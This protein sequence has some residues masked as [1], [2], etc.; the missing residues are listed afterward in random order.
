ML[1]SEK[2]TRSTITGGDPRDAFWVPFSTFEYS[3]PAMRGARLADSRAINARSTPSVP[4]RRVFRQ[5]ALVALLVALTCHGAAALSP[6]RILV[7]YNATWSYDAD[8]D[9][10]QDSMEAAR[11]YC[12]ERSVPEANML[13]VSLGTSLDVTPETLQGSLLTPL[14]AK[15]NGLGKT[16][17]DCILTVIGIPRRYV[18]GSSIR[19]IDAILMAPFSFQQT[20][21]PNPYHEP[22]PTFGN[23]LGTFQHGQST[24]ISGE[25]M[26]LV[27]RLDSPMG[28][29]GV[30]NQID[31]CTYAMRYEIPNANAYVDSIGLV[32]NP[33]TDANL[34]SHDYVRHGTYHTR[35]SADLNI[36]WA[37]HFVPSLTRL[38]W[39]QSPLEIGDPGAMIEAAP[40]CWI[41]AGWYNFQKYQDVIEWLPGSIGC[42]VDSSSAAWSPSRDDRRF[43]NNWENH[44][45]L[46]QAWGAQ[47]MI[48]GATCILG[49]VTEPFLTGHQRPHVAWWS[50]HRG[51]SFAEAATL[52]TPLIGWVTTSIGDPLFSWSGSRFPDTTKPAIQ[53]AEVTHSERDGCVLDVLLDDGDLATAMVEVK[54]GPTIH[55]PQFWRR[56]RISISPPRDGQECQYR[57]TLTDPSGNVSMR[58]DVFHVPGQGPQQ[59]NKV[60]G[61][62]QLEDFDVGGEGIAYHDLEPGASWYRRETGVDVLGT[63]PDGAIYRL[64]NGEWT[65]YTIDAVAG[66]YELR[67][68]LR[69]F[70]GT[71]RVSIDDEEVATFAPERSGDWVE[72]IANGIAISAGRHVVRIEE[73][74]PQEPKLIRDNSYLDWLEFTR[75]GG[76]PPETP[77]IEIDVPKGTE[78]VLLKIE[79]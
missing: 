19:A 12:N 17:I 79:R 23:D 61:T 29:F 20:A 66:T 50:L 39:E 26:Y 49:V 69:Q 37:E 72:L 70:G 52:S 36:A 67:F 54:D 76:K 55:S 63:S 30:L 9:D 71:F 38:R 10:I 64:R 46:H 56:H 27:S 5:L 60:P 11:Y 31:Q 78:R 58:D 53:S 7:V 3:T 14:Q 73:M 13:G 57:L 45:L 22:T 34:K 21:R 6:S 25:P 40:R 1:K 48:R 65:E 44:R 42:D 43:L 15:L 77:T 35:E 33:Q 8:S 51:D 74:S 2:P 68:R 24:T 18:D 62:I 75:T 32:L 16:N 28:I 41:Y 47:A 4:R 59:P